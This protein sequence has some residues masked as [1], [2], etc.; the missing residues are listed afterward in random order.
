MTLSRF[1]GITGRPGIGKTT[2]FLRTVDSLRSLGITVGGFVSREVRVGSDRVGFEIVDLTSNKKGWLAHVSQCDGPRVGKYSVNTSDLV[3]IGVGAIR[4]SIHDDVL[5]AIAV[6]EIGP[7]ELTS[8]DFIRAIGDAIESE[9]IVI[10]TIHYR[11]RNQ[12]LSMFNIKSPV[13]IFEVRIENRDRIH[14]DIKDAV[15]L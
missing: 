5:K 10:A 9:K 11:E 2:V 13:I 15:M 8:Q 6:D 1:V 7:M 3:E 4:R 12:I 14:E